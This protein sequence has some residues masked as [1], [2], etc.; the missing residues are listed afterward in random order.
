MR[1]HNREQFLTAK[2]SSQFR[3]LRGTRDREQYRGD[4]GLH[5][6]ITSIADSDTE[7]DAN[8]LKLLEGRIKVP[9]VVE[10]FNQNGERYFVYE[11]IEGESAASI[12][13]SADDK[14]SYQIGQMIG[15]QLRELQEVD[16][17]DFSHL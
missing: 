14:L 3:Y 1:R 8:T 11:L 13:S 9:K 15:V 4:N 7:R 6:C 17:Q 2:Y 5:V 12:L 16:I 10:V